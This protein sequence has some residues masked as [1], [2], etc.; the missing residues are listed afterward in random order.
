VGDNGE[1]AHVFASQPAPAGDLICLL[2][3]CFYNLGTAF[4][5]WA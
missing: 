4:Y 1:A 3:L 2:Y 5:K